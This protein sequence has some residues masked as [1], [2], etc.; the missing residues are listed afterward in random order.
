MVPAVHSRG[1]G[2]ESKGAVSQWMKRARQG[3]VQALRKRME[4]THSTG[5]SRKSTSLK[6]GCKVTSSSRRRDWLPREETTPGS[7]SSNA[8][9][10]RLPARSALP[11]SAGNTTFQRACSSGGAKSTRLAAR[12]LSQKSSGWHQV[13]INKIDFYCRGFCV[14]R[15]LQGFREAAGPGFEPGLSDSESVSTC[16]RLL[17][18]VR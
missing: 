10:R 4:C 6:I 17:F 15:Y 7:S 14:Y 5:Q 12:Q 13:G 3:G 18:V 11:R 16:S 9:V 2:R 8:A 1:P